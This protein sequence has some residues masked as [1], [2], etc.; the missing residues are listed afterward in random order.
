MR[1]LVCALYLGSVRY[2]FGSSSI[3]AAGGV[4]LDSGY[5]GRKMECLRRGFT[6]EC[7]PH[8]EFRVVVT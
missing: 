2:A 8:F 4:F 5:N 7:S 6:T 1:A 3:A